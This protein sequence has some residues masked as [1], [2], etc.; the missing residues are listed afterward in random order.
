MSRKE[1]QLGFRQNS[2]PDPIVYDTITSFSHDLL[3]TLRL[4]SMEIAQD[5]GYL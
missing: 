4:R 1:A 2:K 5:N 3:K